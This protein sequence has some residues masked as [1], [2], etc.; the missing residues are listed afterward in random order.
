MSES[1][2]G[3][4]LLI[5]DDDD[6]F[7]E[8]L[9]RAFV[10]RGYRVK[11]ASSGA[12]ALSLVENWKPDL[13]VTDLR[14]PGEWGLHVVQEL[15]VEIPHI[16]IVVL[17]AYGSIATALEAIRLGAVHF[18]Q[19]PATIEEIEA[20]LHRL[21]LESSSSLEPP[22]QVPTLARN[23]WEH[24]NRVLTECNGNIRKAALLLG[25]HRRTLQRKLSKFPTL[26]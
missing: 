12:D 21:E 2:S 11:A 8:R 10:S 4:K 15:L 26:R 22:E 7:R 14:M 19:K 24:I 17:S 3:E 5:V 16:K 6:V 9:A 20:G 18:L 25:L 13:A 23:E 1:T